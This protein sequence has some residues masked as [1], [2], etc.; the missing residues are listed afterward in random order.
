MGR[1]VEK[2]HCV[3]WTERQELYELVMDQVIF[4]SK[5]GPNFELKNSHKRFL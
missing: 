3:K 1:R 4:G 2:K 5:N